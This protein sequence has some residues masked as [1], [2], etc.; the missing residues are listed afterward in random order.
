MHTCNIFVSSPGDVALERALVARVTERLRKVFGHR[1]ELR[2]MLWEEQPLEA[3]ASFQPQLPNPANVDLFIMILWQRMGTLL[4]DSA[5]PTPFRGPL[6]GTEYEFLAALSAQQKEGKPAVMVYRRTDNQGKRADA[7]T[8]F[9][10]EHFTDDSFAD[11][12]TNA[13]AD[14]FRRDAFAVCGAFCITDLVDTVA[15]QLTGR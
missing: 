11:S 4:P 14:S 6:T 13:R 2:L 8:A 9:F 7:V 12:V 5:I 15:D 1:S 3:K 10:A